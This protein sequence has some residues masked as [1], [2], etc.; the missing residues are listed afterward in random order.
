M[1]VVGLIWGRLSFALAGGRLILSPAA[2]ML[3]AVLPES[4][5]KT[6]AHVPYSRTG[7]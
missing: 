1:L 3:V 6:Q 5:A 7:Q 4:E 2:G